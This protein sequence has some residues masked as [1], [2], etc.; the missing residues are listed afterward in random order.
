MNLGIRDAIGL[1]PVIISILKVFFSSFSSFYLFPQNGSMFLGDGG[2]GWRS[3]TSYYHVDGLGKQCDNSCQY[4]SGR[5]RDGVI[6]Y[7]ELF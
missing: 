4:A 2:H 7:F 1:G 3:T 6:G 5:V